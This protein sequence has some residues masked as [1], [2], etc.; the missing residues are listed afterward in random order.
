MLHLGLRASSGLGLSLSLALPFSLCSSPGL[1][2]LSNLWLVDLY[3]YVLF[4]QGAHAG[5][6]SL[7]VV[8][9]MKKGLFISGF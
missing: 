4:S 3:M 5:I 7:S 8:E 1:P 6:A 9:K 2:F